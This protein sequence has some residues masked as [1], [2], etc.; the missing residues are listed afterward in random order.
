MDQVPAWIQAISTV[1]LILVTAKYVHL[2]HKLSRTADR[3]LGLLRDAEFHR[4]RADLINVTFLTRRILKSLEELPTTKD[5]PD[6]N[7]R[8]LRASLWRSEEVSELGLLAAK[9][10]PDF[11]R[12]AEQ[13]AVDLNWLLERIGPVRS[14]KRGQGFEIASFPWD[15]YAARTKRIKAALNEIADDAA[16]QAKALTATAS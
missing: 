14:E 10:G 8:L 2:T 4:R 5:D 16:S 13:P 3:Q 7:G 9:A 1:I 11:A 6:P 15:E 12:K